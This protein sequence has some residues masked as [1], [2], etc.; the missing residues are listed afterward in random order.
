MSY[1]QLYD[2]IQGHD[3][4]IERNIVRDHVLSLKKADRVTVMRTKRFTPAICRG[5]YLSPSNK[6]HPFTVVA[7]KHAILV[8][9]GLNQC[10]ERLIVVKELMHLLDGASEALDTGEQFDRVL[11]EIVVN[12]GSVCAQT[13]S[14]F[15]AFWK[16]LGVLVPEA[17]RL[18]LRADW[19][20]AKKEGV[21][22]ADIDI[23]HKLKIPATYIP[24]LFSDQYSRQLSSIL[25]RKI[26]V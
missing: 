24:S 15:K 17:K 25:N 22:S 12:S 5:M 3:I 23:A 7:G 19:L 4:Y 16:A 6:S 14:E 2:A 26:S 21:L 9:H 18:K 11:S 10:W 1:A 8:A 20:K 13:R